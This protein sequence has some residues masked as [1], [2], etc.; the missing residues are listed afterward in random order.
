MSNVVNCSMQFFLF[1]QN[2][3]FLD[4]FV[5]F[6][7]TPIR[8]DLP[9]S[10]DS[11]VTTKLVIT[12]LVVKPKTVPCSTAHTPK[13]IH[14]SHILFRLTICDSVSLK[15]ISLKSERS[16]L[17]SE[18]N[19]GECVGTCLGL[20]L[21]LLSLVL[22]CSVSRVAVASRVESCKCFIFKNSIDVPV[23]F[24]SQFMLSV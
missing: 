10:G 8:F 22:M 12:I 24:L 13:Y 3:K 5:V 18:R 2:L 19:V 17:G 15:A 21:F 6:L 23:L 9:R 7:I 16:N 1:P 11:C 20:E 4:T 14:S